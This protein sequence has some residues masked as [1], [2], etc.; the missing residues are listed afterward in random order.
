M[1]RKKRGGLMFHC[2]VRSCTICK[3]HV[4]E[5]TRRARVKHHEVRCLWGV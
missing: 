1:E 4:S 2:S 5:R 3:R